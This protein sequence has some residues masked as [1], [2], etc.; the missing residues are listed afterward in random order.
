M[1][2]NIFQICI[3]FLILSIVS[4]NSNTKTAKATNK[5]TVET[6]KTKSKDLD[7]SEDFTAQIYFRLGIK[8]P[9]NFLKKFHLQKLKFTS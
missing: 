6:T 7:I 3:V 1:K 8:I 4:S 2:R 9:N 5:N